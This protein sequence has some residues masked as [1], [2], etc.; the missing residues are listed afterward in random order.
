MVELAQFVARL[1]LDHEDIVGVERLRGLGPVDVDGAP[2]AIDDAGTVEDAHAVVAPGIDAANRRAGDA[3]L[4][5][6]GKLLLAGLPF[7]GG[8]AVAADGKREGREGQR[9]DDLTHG[10]SPDYPQLYAKPPE[11]RLT[12]VSARFDATGPIAKTKSS[13]STRKPQC[14]GP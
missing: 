12:A 6:F 13:A 1:G 3:A 5:H 11:Y 10:L 8:G 14:G 2:V 9:S 7:A 4:E